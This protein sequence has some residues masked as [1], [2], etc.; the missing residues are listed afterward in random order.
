MTW[1]ET[2]IAR[3]QHGGVLRRFAP[4]GV[5][6]VGA[7]ECEVTVCTSS[8]ALDDD[9]WVMAG[10][11]LSRYQAHPVVLRDHDMTQPVAR[12]SNLT[13]S[14]QKITALATFAPEGVSAKA[15][16]TR[17]LVKAGFLTGVSASI[18][19]LE[20]ELLDPRN[21]RGGQRIT[22]SILLEFSF[23]S[24]PADTFSGVTA[25]GMQRSA[26][27]SGAANPVRVASAIAEICALRRATINP[28]FTGLFERVK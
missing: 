1:S 9:V 11:D 28:P 21:P 20:S 10:V 6:A 4:V 18:I 19:P 17:G 14:P 5:A 22:R 25:R 7:D 23:V 13:V 24:V 12:A 26:L 2:V 3:R 15:D 27:A 16:E 8:L